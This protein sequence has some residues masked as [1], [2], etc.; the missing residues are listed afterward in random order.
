VFAPLVI[1]VVDSVS[2]TVW[3]LPS[4]DYLDAVPTLWI[5]LHQIIDDW[6]RYTNELSYVNYRN[7]NPD[8]E[9]HLLWAFNELQP[10][11]INCL[12]SYINFFFLL[13]NGFDVL[14]REIKD[15]AK[16][17]KLTIKTP[18]KPKRTNYLDR[19]RMVRNYTVVHWGGPDQNMHIDSRA[20]RYWGL[21]YPLDTDTLEDIRFGHVSLTGATDR[22]LLTLS[23][24]HMECITHLREFDRNCASMLTE[25][26]Q[27]LPITINSRTY[28]SRN[29]KGIT[30]N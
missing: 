1:S 8:R 9:N 16:E 12:F 22:I 27:A 18:K 5:I 13:E 25:I 6:T 15:I 11:Y 30:K 19:V 28:E 26:I 7:I 2:H 21:S 20:G 23:Q 3:M 29:P 24:T 10:R 14:F 4:L 17:L